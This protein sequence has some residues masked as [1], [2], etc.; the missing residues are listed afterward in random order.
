MKTIFPGMPLHSII[1]DL[2]LTNSVAITIENILEGR[3]LLEVS[4]RLCLSSVNDV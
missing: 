1:D 2:R 3:L 4:V